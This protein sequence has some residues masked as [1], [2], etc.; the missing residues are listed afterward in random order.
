MVNKNKRYCPRTD[1][2]SHGPSDFVGLGPKVKD[3]ALALHN[4]FSETDYSIIWV[5]DYTE[6]PLTA[7]DKGVLDRR[8]IAYMQ[9]RG[10]VK[11]KQ[12]RLGGLRLHLDGHIEVNSRT[13]QTFVNT[14]RQRFLDYTQNRLYVR[15]EN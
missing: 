15:D 12:I 4:W 8:F 7:T 3:L 11:R 2:E 1:W 13:D 10:P 14:F 6:K 9:F 5:D